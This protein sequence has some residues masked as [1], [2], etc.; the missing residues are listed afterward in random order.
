M[1][2]TAS[3]EAPS[4]A[5]R[6]AIARPMPEPAPVIS[7]WR[8]SSLMQRGRGRHLLGGHDRAAVAQHRGG[9]AR[10]LGGR[11]SGRQ[12]REARVQVAGV[13][14]VAGA[15]GVDDVDAGLGGHEL[16]AADQRAVGAELDHDLLDAE[17]GDPLERRLRVAVAVQRLLVVERRQRERACGPA[18]RPSAR[19]AVAASGQP[20]GR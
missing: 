12:A 17:R 18:R 6:S 3:T 11:G 10:A 13:E 8:P 14:G 16:A 20:A 2:P 7:A 4:R 9:E 19:A 1:R 5:K 15:G